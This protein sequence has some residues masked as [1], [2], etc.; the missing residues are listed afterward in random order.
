MFQ[1]V[2]DSF[3]ERIKGE[4]VPL[5]KPLKTLWKSYHQR[6]CK[7]IIVNSKEQII[8]K[9]FRKTEKV[10]LIIYFYTFYALSGI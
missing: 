5:F 8:K 4:V 3:L 2:Q 9:P 7:N 1:K 10:F 6:Y